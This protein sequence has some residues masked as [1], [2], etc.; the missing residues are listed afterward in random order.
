MDAVGA[1]VVRAALPQRE[2]RARAPSRSRRRAARPLPA[3]GPSRA[4]TARASQRGGSRSPTRGR[5]PAMT[6]WSRSS[7]CSRRD[8]EPRISPSA[9]GAQAKR[10]GAEVH[11]LRLGLLGREQP[12]PG[13]F[14]LPGFRQHE[15]G[16]TLEAKAEGRRLRPLLSRA[17]V[18]QAPGGHQVDEQDELAVI[19]REEQPLRA[20]LAL[21]TGAGPP[22]P[23]AAGRSSSASRCA[24]ARPSRSER[25]RR[26]VEA[27]RQASISGSSGILSLSSWLSRSE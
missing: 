12:D 21:R 22:A 10:L 14:L 19:G 16:A 23:R 2:T 5:C 6:R 25:P 20:P 11:E 15:L 8:S 27:R 7:E 1:L 24:Q 9:F 17:E 4:R 13:T 26:A 18:L 3:S